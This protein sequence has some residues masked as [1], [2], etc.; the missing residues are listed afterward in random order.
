[1][2]E[3]VT[4]NDEVAGSIPSEGI[5][6]HLHA[7]IFLHFFGPS[8]MV[9]ESFSEARNIFAIFFG[10]SGSIDNLNILLLLLGEENLSGIF[11]LPRNGS[12]SL[13]I[14][15]LHGCGSRQFGSILY[16]C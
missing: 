13:A 16:G 1:M 12:K 8:L 9:V 2:V 14:K 3:R 5:Q 7:L 6:A 11:S 4:S 10:G 15:S